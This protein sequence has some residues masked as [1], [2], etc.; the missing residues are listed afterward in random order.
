LQINSEKRPSRD[1]LQNHKG[2]Y[3][4]CRQRLSDS[5]T[6]YLVPMRD[7]KSRRVMLLTSCFG[8]VVSLLG[9]TLCVLAV[10]VVVCVP[11]RE[12]ACRNTKDVLYGTYSSSSISWEE[13]GARLR[14][15]LRVQPSCLSMFLLFLQ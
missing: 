12:S 3:A 14:A 5:H 11:V 10:L 15:K 9:A 4:H 6:L 2:E 13:G 8:F 7:L 1:P